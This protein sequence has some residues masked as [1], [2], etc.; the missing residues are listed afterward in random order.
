MILLACR[1]LAWPVYAQTD[2]V[3]LEPVVIKGFVPE[4]FMSGLKIQRIDSVPLAQLRFQNIGDILSAYTPIAF[5]NYGPGQL[6]TASFRGTSANHTAVLW[7][8]LNINAPTLGQTDFSTIPVAGFDQLSVQY[9]SAASIV[10]SDAVGGSILLESNSSVSPFQISAGRQRE[11]FDN[12]QTQADARYA[13]S[14]SNRWTFS[15]K[16]GIYNSRMNNNYP[17][18]TRRTYALLP[19]ETFQ[20]GIVQDLFLRSRSDQEISAHIW[21]TDNKLVLTPDDLQGREM[22]R[23]TAYRTIVRY[24]M[25]TLTLRSAWVRDIIDYA[26]GDISRPDHSVTDKFASRVEKDFTLNIG[27]NANPVYLK[28]GGEWT[29]Y[30]SRVPGYFRMPVI[31]N[32][33]DFFLLTRWQ[34]TSRLTTSINLRQGL[35]TGFNPPFTPSIGMEYSLVQKTHYHLALKGS[36]GRSYRVPTLN[37]R[38]WKDLGNPDVR[39]ETGWNKEAGLEQTFKA[40]LGGTLRT[41]ATFYHNRIKE[42]T[43]WNPSRGYRVENLQQVLARGIELQMNYQRQNGFWKTGIDAGY[44]FNRSSQEKAYDNYSQDIVGKQLVFV[45]EHTANANAFVQYKSTKLTGQ[46]Q[47]AS[48]RYTTFDNSQFLDGYGL[49]NLLAETSF[50]V[51]KC[52]FL[53]QGQIRN[54]TDTF[55][56]NVRNNAMPGRSFALSLTF[57]YD[58]Q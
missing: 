24:R 43:Y 30:R 16:T 31:E 58:S 3:A 42:W 37:E 54:V 56:L 14:L 12:H 33:T 22:T 26:K 19:T 5:R 41:S 28:T 39:P 1:A 4:K 46:L 17:K 49:V 36:Y 23:T 38:Y 25:R 32:R 53:V 2:S 6:S 7:N 40:A 35:V 10:G 8:G 47:A 55:Y 27:E 21:L 18:P 13:W 45:P 44:A 15:G 48:K 51:Q 11:S 50:A 57:S 9:G 20:K 34:P 29:H 52:R